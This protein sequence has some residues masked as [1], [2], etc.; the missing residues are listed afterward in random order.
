[1]I[2]PINTVVMSMTSNNLE[3]TKQYWAAI[4]QGV[5]TEKMADFFSNDFVQVEFPNRLTPNG[6]K[7]DLPAIIEASK[8]GKK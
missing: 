3:I 5:E 1:M 4:E 2:F 8:R 7:R 6:A